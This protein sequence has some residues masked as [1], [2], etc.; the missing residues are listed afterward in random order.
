MNQ[1]KKL[2][3]TG[4]GNVAGDS[5][6]PYL[7]GREDLEI[8]CCSRSPEKAKKFAERFGVKSC[9]DL[10]ELAEMKPD[11]IFILTRENYHCDIANQLLEFS[12]KRLFIEKPLQARDG[13]ANVG[14]QDF[15]EAYDLLK[16]AKKT[17]TEIAM[18]FNYRFFE[19]T[20]RLERIIR[21]KDLGALLQSSWLVHYACWSH[22]I[23]LLLRFN[24]KIVEVG[25]LSSGRIHQSKDQLG[26]DLAGA[27]VAESGSTGIIMGTVGTAFE[28]QLYHI[29]LNF[30]RGTVI[31]SDLDSGMDVYYRGNDYCESHVLNS[32]RSRWDQ[33]TESFR[34][35]LAAYLESIDQR[36][37]QAPP[38]TGM[39]GLKELQF[40]V[41][42]RR[43]VA[44]G[45]KVIIDQEFGIQL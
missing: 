32:D 26:A 19:Q 9:R 41:A 17:G 2:G 15:F 42:L 30:E 45:R 35:S 7:S 6:L 22:C 34:K 24:G 38:V 29:V 21:E 10:K 11:A 36:Q 44:T 20:L 43:S 3:I 27:F 25:S 14:E 39:D 23:D 40:E 28:H 8:T 13:Q 5:Y 16:R 12:P 33:Y 31:L 4:L 18:N 1:I 37:A